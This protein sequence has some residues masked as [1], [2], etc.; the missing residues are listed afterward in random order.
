MVD[1]A[2]EGG[3]LPRWI[4][5][6]D[7]DAFYAA[8]EQHDNPALMGRPVI[9]GGD[10]GSRGVVSTCSYEARAFG[11]RSAMPLREAARRC[12]HGA[13][14][15]VRMARYVEV[16]R[17][18][19]AILDR[20]SPLVEPLSLDEAFLDAT[21]C[22]R[23]FGPAVCMARRI[24]AEIREQLGLTASVGI[25]PNKF[26]AKIASDLRKPGGFVV[27]RP[28]EEEAFLADLPVGRLWGVG[29]KTEEQL[30]RMGIAT[31]GALRGVPRQALAAAFGEAGSQL[32]EL[33]RGRDDRPV[34]PGE[35]AKSIGQEITFQE[36]T[37]DREFLAATLLLL[38][39]RVARRARRSGVRGRTIV[40]KLRDQD[41]RTCT[42]RQTLISPTDREEEIYAAAKEL[43]AK[44]AWGG[45]KVRLLGVA[46][47]NLV[48]SGSGR[49]G[50]LFAMDGDSRLDRL[51]EAVDWVRER[52][53]EDAL[54]RAAVL[55]RKRTTGIKQDLH[56]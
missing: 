35:A 48:A 17:Q 1:S 54:V 11:V 39:D 53:G 14:V 56:D 19:F 12:P 20:Y 8:V 30:R 26:L 5:H 36:D 32:Y 43:A 46:L 51:H 16:S 47:A 44:I 31:I 22:E 3:A 15:P 24:V 13:F 27:V 10:P 18:V 55:R 21:G 37:A 49:Q 7:M 6:L 50:T 9:V 2:W 23:L 52:Y 38:A 25:A 45:G 42:R 33:C 34:S 41:F 28:G 40:L 29:P 4:I